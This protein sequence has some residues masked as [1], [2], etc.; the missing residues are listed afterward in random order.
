MSMASR[1]LSQWLNQLKIPV[2]PEGNHGTTNNS[3]ESPFV[4]ILPLLLFL[5]TLVASLGGRRPGLDKRWKII[6]SDL[7]LARGR[8]V[9]DFWFAAN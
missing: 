7:W 4:L 9:L 6:G 1:A 8:A 5:V 3:G 2:P